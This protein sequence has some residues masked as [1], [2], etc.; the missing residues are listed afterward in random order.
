MIN[1]GQNFKT[2][3][4]NLVGSSV[5]GR[6][7]KISSEF[8]YNMFES[9]GFMVPYSGYEIA[10]PSRQ[11]NGGEEG[12]GIFSS[13]KLNKLVVVIDDNVYLVEISYDPLNS[14]P[15][16]YQKDF[17]GKL[18]TSTGIVYIAENNKPQI[19]ISDLVNLYIYDAT[20]TPS[21]FQVTNIDFTPGYLTFHDTYFICA[22]QVDYF[23][24]PPATNT[25]RLSA[26][27]DG[28][29]W[30]TTNNIGLIQSKPDN[31]QAVVRFPSR[32]NMIL[33]MGSTVTESW[34]DVGAQLFPYQRQNQYNFDYGCV[35]PA[36]VAYNDELVVWLGQNEKSGPIILYSTG[37]MPEKL[38]T[39]GLDYY[40]AQLTN[41]ADSQGFLYRQDGHLFYHINFYTD[42]LSLFIDFLPDGTHKI[43][44]AC[45]QALNYFIAAQ[46]AYFNNQYY[47][48]TPN[49][50]NLFSF[51]T[52]FTTYE[53]VDLAG[54][55][56]INE[57]P[58]IRICQNIR[59]PSQD[60]FVVN[61]IGVTIESGETNYYQQNGINSTPRVDLSISRDGGATFGSTVPYVLP[62]IG[63]R[64]NKCLWWQIG[65]ANDLVCQFK[66]VGFGRFVLT[67][68][69]V[70]IR[71]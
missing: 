21:F 71:Q 2:V 57:I 62:S 61:D 16:F 32:G 68:G 56:V 12:R 38:T 33:V 60:Y 64:K 26:S 44:H 28:S 37:G 46:V 67:N 14:E 20:Q 5:F 45:D 29:T 59:M 24:S 18:Q 65:I 42:N 25:W 49:N 34:F 9:D 17:I 6:Y 4:L 31:T 58:R 70:N 8:T 50:G 30:T 53:D 55:V 3:P 66:F 11:F 52:I 22:A 19:C 54:N 40:F 47:F 48:I 36:T 35:S 23:Y 10:M 13:I 27:N 63:Q 15:Y 41:P 69:E 7:P 51:D 1:R 43:Y 39:D